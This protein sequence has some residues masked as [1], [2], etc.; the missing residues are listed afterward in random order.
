MEQIFDLPLPEQFLT[1]RLAELVGGFRGP[2]H[3]YR[4]RET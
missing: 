1:S 2:L 4:D 3:V